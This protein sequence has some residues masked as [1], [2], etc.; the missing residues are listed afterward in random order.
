MTLDFLNTQDILRDM[1]TTGPPLLPLLRSEG[2]ARVLTS[3]L[4]DPEE[5]RT[6][7]DLAR[8]T[9]VSLATVT[10]EIQ[11]A[12]RAGIVKS[13][14][15]GRSKVVEPNPDSPLTEPL[16]RLLLV[17]F[18]PAIVAREELADVNEI[19]EA[20]VFG[21]WAARYLGESG[22]SPLDLDILVV[23]APDRQAVY[24]AADRIERRIA[25]PVQVVL[26]TE[27]EWEEGDDPFLE[28]LKRRPL[29]PLGISE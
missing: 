26:R 1:K 9:G 10:R 5:E 29:V 19:K 23:G 21:S 12:E 27:H 22:R 15:V 17:S 7:S 18:G 11:R 3:I 4:L 8:E 13:H 6:L 28:E 25:R 24:Q 2:Q 14:S 20:Y 16:T